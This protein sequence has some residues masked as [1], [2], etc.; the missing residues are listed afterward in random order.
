M[1]DLSRSQFDVLHALHKAAGPLTQRQLREHTGMSLGRVNSAVRECEARGWIANRTLTPEGMEALE[2]HRVRNAVI[3]AAGLSQR[4][5]PISYERP[6]ATLRVRGEVLIERQIRQLHE[7]G[8]TDVTVVVGYKKE[9]LFYLA[10]VFGVNIVVNRDY[11]NRNNNGSLWAVRELLD[12]TYICS[13][14]DYF[15][16]NPFESHVHKAYYSSLFVAGPT[17]EWCLTTGPEGRIT[18]A[19]VGGADSWIMLGHVYWDRTFSRTFRTLLE[20]VYNL[21]ETAPKLWESIYLDN[22]KH[23]DMVIRKY[24]EGVINEFD[25]LAELRAFDPMFM[26]NLDSAVFDHI[27]GTLGCTKSEVVDFYPLKQGITNLSCHFRVGEKEYV[28]RHPGVGTEKMVDRQ[29]ET[30]ALHLAQQLGVDST[31]VS[32]DPARGWKIS[33]FVPCAR[34]LDVTNDDELSLAMQMG[35][36]LHQSGAVLSRSFDFVEEGLRY[37]SLL[38]EHG[39]IVLPGYHELRDKVLRLKAKADADGFPKVPSHNDFF[40]LNF[41]V[42]QDGHLD[43]IDW[44]YAGMSDIAS[45][46]G[47]MVVCAELSPERGDRALEAYFGRTPTSVERRHFWSYVVFAGWCWYLWSL[48]KEAEGDDVGEW[49]FIYYRHAVNYVDAL[50]EW[51]S[52]DDPKGPTRLN[53]NYKDKGVR[54]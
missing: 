10:D 2:P 3:M 54:E 21:P 32:S 20:R 47:T 5:A 23:F 44:E 12:N 29:A 43:L 42:D 9:H 33:R 51:Y 27:T 16:V 52:S 19:T 31:F 25:S 36:N 41:L 30:D 1:T 15:T 49:L 11:V 35:R 37:E 38:L 46:F 28:Y 6:K 8:I 14:D 40:P 4:L 53:K 34:N 39:P 45:D 48:L 7:A 50:L 17:E 22:V 18:G 13:S 24:P 26:E